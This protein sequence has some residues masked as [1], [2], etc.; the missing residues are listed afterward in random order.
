MHV[1]PHH[2]GQELWCTGLVRHGLAAASSL[3]QPQIPCALQNISPVKFP[4]AGSFL[5]YH[6]LF[7]QLW[8]QRVEISSSAEQ[9]Q[10]CLPI[11]ITQ[12]R[13]H[14]FH[15]YHQPWHCV[16]ELFWASTALIT[17][18][19]SSSRVAIDSTRVVAPQ[20]DDLEDNGAWRA[21]KYFSNF[22]AGQEKMDVMRKQAGNHRQKSLF[23]PESFP[24]FNCSWCLSHQGLATSFL[25]MWNGLQQ[26]GVGNTGKTP[27]NP[28]S[29]A[30][31]LNKKTH[32]VKSPPN[33]ALD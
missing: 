7:V 4:F 11:W 9:S 21:I 22:E 2:W 29:K 15:F 12:H 19:N 28:S 10:P 16:W 27:K 30:P 17:L 31:K 20:D 33:Y 1:T 8:T 14:N 25:V 32:T 3:P 6:H 5:S 13:L 18:P 23:V 24:H 26:I